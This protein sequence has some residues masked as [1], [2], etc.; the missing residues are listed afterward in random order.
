MRPE[1]FT[2]QSAQA[3]S[4]TA[5]GRWLDLLRL[6]ATEPESLIARGKALLGLRRD[7]EGLECFERV[8]SAS[9]R[10]PAALVGQCMALAR[11]GRTD[12]ALD[13][14]D[15]WSSKEPGCPE[16]EGIR[17]QILFS[18]G[19][20]EEAQ[21]AS[22]R[23]CGYNPPDATAVLVRGMLS[24]E[25]GDTSVALEDFDA[26][27]R[28]APTLA[29]AYHA[30]GSACAGLGRLGD[31]LD[32]FGSARR[33][34]PNN[35]GIALGMGHL[36]IR[37]NRY[38][39]ALDAFDAALDIRPQQA[40]ALQGRAQCLAALGRAPEALEAYTCLLNIVPDADYMRGERFH[41][42][43]HCCDWRD[44][45]SIRL[46]LAE[47]L[48][49]GEKVDN[50]GSFMTHNDSPADQRLCA[51][52][53]AGDV[54]AAQPNPLF[55]R[56]R[57]E[58]ERIR[59]AYFSADFGEHATA[60]LA[61]GLFE[62]HD[63]SKFE[64]YAVSFGPADDSPMRR[65]LTKAFDHFEDVRDLTDQQVVVWVRE[66]GIDIAVDMKG[67]T[68]GARPQI[69][70]LRVAPI[71]VSFLGY[72]GT[73]GA[74]FMDYIVADRTVIPEDE[75]HHY[76]EQV[77]YLPG[78][79]QVNDSARAASPPVS[80][81]D[82]GLPESGFVFCC[83]NACYKITPAVFDNWMRILGAVPGSVLWLLE[84]TT[85]A[86]QSLRG[87]AERYGVQS[88]RLIFAPWVSVADHLSRCALADVFLDTTP[89]NAHTTASDA[90]W[91]G[92]PVIT[93]AGSAFA[94]R[95]ATSLLRGV[96]LEALSVDSADAYRRL[97]IHLAESPTALASLKSTLAV[98]R[99][100]SP[101]FDS[102]RY[103]RQLEAAFEELAVRSRRGESPS[104][105]DADAWLRRGN[106]Q[107]EEAA[108]DAAIASYVNALR[109]NPEFPAALN[110][111]GHCFR[112]LRR[113]P[114]ALA[115]FERALWLRPDYSLAFNNQGLALMDLQ[116]LREALHSFDQALAV[117][118]HAVEVLS[119]RGT[120][121][122]AM[123]RF[124]E[125][126]QTFARLT[127]IAPRFGGALGS[128]LYARRNCCDW[129]DYEGLAQRV[130]D[131]VGAGDLADLPL[132]FVGICDSPNAQLACARTFSTLRYPSQTP[133]ARISESKPTA[134]R[135][136][137]GRIRVAYLSGDFGEH[138]V[139][140]LLAGVIEHHDR[141]RFEAVAVAWGRRNEGTMRARLESAF[142]VFIDVTDMPDAEIAG[143][144]RRMGV[145][146]A[147]DLTGHTGGQRTEIF[148]RRAA[149]LQVNYLGFPATT[150]VPEMDYLLADEFLIPAEHQNAY[151]ER[152]VYLPECFQA[153]DD[154]RLIDAKTPTRAE[155]GL[156]G[157]AFV[158]CSFHGIYKF[159]PQLFD[160][161]V[162]LV[163]G[164]PDSVLW[165][166]GG[167][168]TVEA[169]LRHEA[170][171]RGLDPRRLIFA[172][173][174][175]YPQHLARLQLADLCLD[176]LPF[177][178]G[179]TTS[180]ALWAG[181]PVVTCAGKSFAAR[182]SG[183]LLH[184]LGLPE[185][186]TPSLSDYESLASRLAGDPS[187]LAGVRARLAQAR[188]V[189][190][191][192]DATR[193]CRHLEAAYTEMVRRHDA[194][195]PPASFR[196]P[197]LRPDA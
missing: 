83:F 109:L 126:A 24:L 146:V 90:L 59:I 172:S 130:T 145:D 157:A 142:D 32:D 14:L 68:L 116:R 49:R 137:T 58:G 149:P 29:T 131:A 96:G 7:A 35:A 13:I 196:V 138:A 98:A 70:A 4:L 10:S 110:N 27:I 77:I 162:R 99:Y 179:A 37:L 18:T 33:L 188:M 168:A 20:R 112:V 81:R 154:R 71:Q 122:L 190:P 76:A 189:S 30:R 44:Y 136:R 94:G 160:V 185:L 148:T 82:V 104:P 56:H 169:N 97:A 173:Y 6:P 92:V 175:P 180:D 80:R 195:L 21:M 155:L 79:Y 184:T 47:R 40:Q 106:L 54:C 11:L 107:Q 153:N 73:L 143:Q 111:M 84:A 100:R 124:S 158:W 129:T 139:S 23:G 2:A 135:D 170:A 128:L 127:E 102:V 31:A 150:G 119:N 197:P 46:D 120:V 8:L 9:P 191:A 5:E 25:L 144:L 15:R 133:V 192:F 86:M 156:P 43:L 26:A 42:Q 91:S 66:R 78:C 89:Y 164:A 147:V 117:Q 12:A 3:R 51:Q 65:R 193:F 53:F 134:V 41:V 105:L 113:L 161:W 63:K 69:F 60:Y 152:V 74:D 176:T 125:A 61:A 194:G 187:R 183:S 186:V 22:I 39:G 108:Y 121:L 48:R 177:N 167:N 95:V 57:P 115:A 140:Y 34:D 174:L 16:I 163:R 178:G 182:M 55:Q 87:E 38:D 171:M 151:S 93:Q 67:H 75:R 17:A 101:L 1:K 62:A 19:R 36:L 181:V 141:S 114:E 166:V 159:N 103:C 88:D 85:P 52:I 118:P 165:L 45:D 132:S 64:T 123:K 72:P 50:P 28:L